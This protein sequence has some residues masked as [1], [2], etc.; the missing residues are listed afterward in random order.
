MLLRRSPGQPLVFT[1]TLEGHDPPRDTVGL[2]AI[3]TQLA[4]TATRTKGTYLSALYQRLAARR[5]KQRAI[6]AVAHSIMKSIFYML[7]RNAPYHELG[8]HYF[9]ERQ[10]HSTVDRLARRIEH[11]GY[12]VH[13]EPVAVP[14]A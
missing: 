4:P 7:S 12:R 1:R 14:A 11:L 9:D 8:A 3:L 10:R 6:I 5:G 2:R 13:L